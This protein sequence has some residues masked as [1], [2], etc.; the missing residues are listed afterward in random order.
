MSKGSLYFPRWAPHACAPPARSI[1]ANCWSGRSNPS[2]CASSS[3]PAR[4]VTT[5]SCTLPNSACQDRYRRLERQRHFCQVSQLDSHSL[6][7]NGPQ[8]A[9]V[10]AATLRSASPIDYSMRICKRIRH[11]P[12][13]HLSHPA[14]ESCSLSERQVKP[15]LGAARLTKST[16]NLHRPEESAT[17]TEAAKGICSSSL[18]DNDSSPVCESSALSSS[19][20]IASPTPKTKLSKA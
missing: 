4:P 10:P 5:R 7:S 19:S 3:D 16:L 1:S 2:S 8:D 20:M 15:S 12:F 14:K 6:R 9:P 17:G 13:A 18:A 11:C